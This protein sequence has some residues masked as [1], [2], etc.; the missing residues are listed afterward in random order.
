M[1]SIFTSD[2]DGVR[3]N[4]AQFTLTPVFVFLEAIDKALL[5]GEFGAAAQRA[6]RLLLRYGE[7][8]EAPRFID[9][10]S[11]HI[12]GCLYHG[13]SGLD[14]VRA[15]LG[16]DARVRVPTS[17][18]VMAVDLVHPERFEASPALVDDQR[19]LLQGYLE[20]GCAPTLTCAPYQRLPRPAF[21]EHVAW[22][23]SNAT[24]FVNSCLGARSDRYGDFTDLCAALT[25]RVPEAGLHR[26]ENRRAR[27]VLRVPAPERCAQDRD[28]WFACLG[29]LLGETAHDRVAVIVGAPPDSS[30][31]ELKALGAAAASSG[32]VALFHVLGVTPEAS[33]LEDVLDAEQAPREV[34]LAPEDFRGVAARLCRASEG[35]VV[36]AFCAGTPHFSLDEFR[37][38]A[39]AVDGRRAAVEVLVSTSR[40]IAERL[41]SVSWA[42]PLWRFGVRL[43]VDTCTYLTPPA[44]TGD[45][46]VVT[47]SAKWAHYAPGTIGRRAALMSLERCVRCAV[48]GRIVP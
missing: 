17:L 2:S 18:N 28:L 29:Y 24:V 13:P 19:E 41:E 25:G 20:L 22:A 7:A 9:I 8:L 15:F 38:L 3:V 27:L 43:I 30:E 48:R 21:G 26:S 37:R 42:E 14:F 33:S 10:A 39:V 4:W 5:A 23:E 44:L 46:W 45:G 32:S 12:D 11:A 34:A 47:P 35:E 6:M 16:T 36:A 1:R 40:A 31:D